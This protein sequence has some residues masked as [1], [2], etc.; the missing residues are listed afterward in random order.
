MGCLSLLRRSERSMKRKLFR[1]MMLLATVLLMTLLAGLLLFG[2]FTGARQELTEDLQVQLEVFSQEI[3]SRC[4]ETAVTGALMSRELTAILETTLAEEQKTFADLTDNQA[5]LQLVQ[6]RMILPLRQ[7]MLQ[8]DCSGAFFLLDATVNSAVPDADVSRSGLYLQMAQP[9]SSQT[10]VLLY[11]GSSQVGKAHGIMPHRKWRL[12]LRTDRFP[13]YALHISAPQQ[14][15]DLSY[16]ITDLFTLPG[17]SE[18]AMLLTVP[19]VGSDGSLLGIC[20]FEISQSYFQANAA[21]PTRLPYLTCLL[22]PA[23]DGTLDADAGLSCGVAGGYYLPPSGLLTV[24]PNSGELLNITGS[25]LPYVGLLREISLAPESRPFTLAVLSPKQNLDRDV[26][27]DALQLALLSLL[28]LFFTVTCCYSFSRRFLTPVLR[29]LEQLKSRESQPEVSGYQEIDDL[30]GYLAQQDREHES[31]LR[32]LE[33]DMQETQRQADLIRLQ[34]QRTRDEYE[35]AQTRLSRLASDQMQEVDPEEYHL[36]L[37]GLR[38]LTP[39]ER[40]I[41]HY[42]LEGHSVREILSIADIKESTHRYHNRNIYSKLGV[43][44]LKQLLRYAALMQTQEEA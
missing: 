22:A 18:Q 37:E 15:L 44:S 33:A 29:S 6:E 4:E 10:D 32:S 19:M 7:M 11:R 20:G 16:R 17:T 24:S 9:T 42:Y 39:T 28:L 5:L 27:H 3:S 12:E 31:A 30:F 2:R 25:S 8:A 13:D 34:Y 36:F 38:K 41:F 40:D 1:Y 43:H 26:L 35:S 23:G 14:P 21:Q